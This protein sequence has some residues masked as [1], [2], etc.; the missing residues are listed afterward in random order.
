[1]SVEILLMSCTSV[2]LS[3]RLA[4]A[5]DH[6]FCVA[7]ALTLHLCHV[8]LAGIILYYASVGLGV[9][10]KVENFMLSKNYCINDRTVLFSEEIVFGL[11]L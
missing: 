4:Q 10:Y 8:G 11:G 5:P 2:W 9:F 6:F 3:R 1:M 7:S